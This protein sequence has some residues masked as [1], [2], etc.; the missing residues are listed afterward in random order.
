M[1]KTVN[2]LPT[3]LAAFALNACN[4]TTSHLNLMQATGDDVAGTDDYEVQRHRIS[5]SAL[6]DLSDHNFNDGLNSDD[7]IEPASRLLINP[8]TGRF[9][10]E[11]APEDDKDHR[12]RDTSNGN[13]DVPL[14]HDEIEPASRLLVNPETG[15]F[16]KD[17][18]TEHDKE[19][20]ISDIGFV[21]ETGNS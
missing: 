17:R 15:R 10:K 16:D 2:I 7:T 8:E 6:V 18:A 5:V 20:E 19:D 9:D 1:K 3:I 12:L 4:V 11:G 21:D 14:A 13:I